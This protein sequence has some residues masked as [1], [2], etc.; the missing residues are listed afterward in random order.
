MASS[1]RFGEVLVLA[2]DRNP[3]RRSGQR[4]DESDH[5]QCARRFYVEAH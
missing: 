1:R 5:D 2:R 4:S 3:L